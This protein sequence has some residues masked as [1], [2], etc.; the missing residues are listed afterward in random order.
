M[1]IHPL[2]GVVEKLRNADDHLQRLEAATLLYLN[3]G[4]N[5]AVVP[6]RDISNPTRGRMVF[7][8]VRQPPLKLAAI[9][10][11]VVHNLRSALDYFV[12]ELVKRERHTPGFQHQFPICSTPESFA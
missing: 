9:A 12:E 11:D 5:G 1:N 6:Q 7:K 2:A 3:S 10:G 8:V 4:S